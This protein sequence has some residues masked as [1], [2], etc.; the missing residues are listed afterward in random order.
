MKEKIIMENEKHRYFISYSTPDGI[1]NGEI[2][3][4]EILNIDSIRE[5]ENELQKEL[6]TTYVNIIFYRMF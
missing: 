3:R 2:Y 1:F 5:I 4:E 6:D